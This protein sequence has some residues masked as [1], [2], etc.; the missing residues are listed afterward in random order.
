LKLNTLA[1][2]SACG[3]K[4]SVLWPLTGFLFL[5]WFIGSSIM[6]TPTVVHNTVF[7]V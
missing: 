2:L 3:V 7:S 1:H 5:F 6:R 4:R